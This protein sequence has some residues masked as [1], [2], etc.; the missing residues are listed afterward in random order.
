MRLF[1]NW[2]KNL[3]FLLIG[4]HLAWVTCHI[5]LVATDGVNPWK[6]GGYA[7]YTQPHYGPSVVVR[8][9]P[10]EA[11]VPGTEE[12][13]K[14]RTSA[15]YRANWNFNLYCKPM[16]KTGLIALFE[17]NPD[18]IGKYLSLDLFVYRFR[19]KPLRMDPEQ[20][21]DTVVTWQDKN[22]FT[23]QTN[24]CGK[25]LSPQKVQYPN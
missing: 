22:T 7:M 9:L 18:L 24:I 12:Y 13:Y 8:S 16:T 14:P 15:F 2:R 5:Y 25:S 23:Y 11:A 20:V 21:G 6:M 1:K 3:L 19:T 10:D 17:N 4:I